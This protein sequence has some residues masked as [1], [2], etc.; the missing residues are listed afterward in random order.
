MMTTSKS[1]KFFFPV[2]L[3]TLFPTIILAAT[4]DHGEFT[5]PS[6]AYEKCLEESEWIYLRIDPGENFVRCESWGNR[7][8]WREWNTETDEY[9]RHYYWGV[10]HCHCGER[11]NPAT[12]KCEPKPSNP[13]ADFNGNGS[14]LWYSHVGEVYIPDCRQELEHNPKSC[15]TSKAAN[16]PRIFSG[17]PIDCTTGNKIQSET[18]YLGAGADPLQFTQAFSSQDVTGHSEMNSWTQGQAPSITTEVEVGGLVIKRLDQGNGHS[19]LFYGIGEGIVTLKSSRPELGTLVHIDGETLRMLKNGASQVFDTAGN[20]KANVSASGH[21]SAIVTNAAGQVT[22]VSNRFGQKLEVTYNDDGLMDTLVDP[23]GL[24]TRFAYNDQ[25]N[26]ERVTFPDGTPDDLYDNPYKVYLYE[27]VRFPNFITGILDENGDRFATWTYNDQGQAITSEHYGAAEK[28]S[29]DYL[30]DSRTEITYRIDG[31]RERKEIR[32]HQVIGGSPRI[33]RIEHTQCDGCTGADEVWVYNSAGQVTGH[34][35]ARSLVTEYSYDERGNRT[36]KVEAVGTAEERITDTEWHPTL[37]LP[38]RVTQGDLVTEYVYNDQNQVATARALDAVT[39][40]VRET[41]YTYTVQGLV[42]TVD[43]PRTDLSDLMT[44]DYDALGNLTRVTNAL[45]QQVNYPSYDPHGRPLQVIDANGLSMSL[46]YTARGWLKSRTVAGATTTYDY[47]KVGQVIRIT[48]P[49]GGYINYEYDAAHRLVA[50]EDIAGN[51][52]DYTLDLLGNATDTQTKGSA[53][54]LL[55]HQR[56]VFD[57]LGRLK[58]VRTSQNYVTT[59]G[60]DGN[61]NLIT[62]QDATSQTTTRS[63][64]HLDRL[65]SLVDANQGITQ[66]A[67]DAQDRLW[68]VTDPRSLVTEYQY[69]ALG[70]LQQQVSPDTGSTQFQYDAAGNLLQ[71][72]DARGVIT[73]YQYDAFNRLTQVNYPGSPE[74][75]IYYAYDDTTNGNAGIGRLTQ[76]TDQTGTTTFRYDIRGLVVE[77]TRVIEGHTY[78]TSYT[79][80]VAQR[81]SQLTYP[82]GRLVHYHYNEL[83]QINRVTTH[84]DASATEQTVISEVSY[85]PFGPMQSLTYGNGLVR[86]LDYNQ[87]YQ[88]VG[89]HS[90]V[91][92]KTYHYDPLGNITG[93]SDALQPDQSQTFIYDPLSRLSE[94]LGG[95][96]SLSFGYDAVGNRTQKT[97]TNDTMN[98]TETYTYANDSNRLL[99]VEQLLNGDMSLRTLT[100]NEVGNIIGD[101]TDARTLALDYNAQNRLDGVSKNGEEL[102]LYLHNALGQRVIKVATDPT[103]NQHFHYDQNGLLLAETQANGD[104]QRETIYL[105]GTPVA[106]LVQAAVTPNR[107]PIAVADH[108]TIQEDGT[109]EITKTSLLLNDTD[110]DDNVLEFV[111]FSNVTP[112]LLVTESDSSLFV[113]PESNINGDYAFTYTISDGQTEVSGQVTISI[114]PVN[115]APYV[116][117]EP[118]DQALME[119]LPWSYSFMDRFGDS[120]ESDSLVFTL[121]WN[122]A[123]LPSWLVYD[124]QL[125]LLSGTPTE[126]DI[127]IHRISITATDTGNL[128]VTTEFNLTIEQHA[129]HRYERVKEGT[130]SNETIKGSSF[131]D[132]YI[133]GKSG[134]DKLYGY[135]GD[136]YLIGGNGND[137]L[138]AREGNDFMYGG[139]GRDKLFGDDGN[140]YLSGG[141]G[142]DT[143]YGHGGHDTLVGGPGNDILKGS[144]GNDTFIYDRGDGSDSISTR[145]T[146][147]NRSDILLFREKINPEDVTA[148]RDEDDLKLAIDGTLEVITVNKFFYNNDPTYALTF[149]RFADGTEWDLEFVRQLI[150][151]Q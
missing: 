90:T 96:G 59:Y 143:L 12:G 52:I 141:D 36:R 84:E 33:T 126:T 104:I 5:P 4:I 21:S 9:D 53:G 1:R 127:G 107:A 100:Y 98:L 77:E 49:N 24:I 81:L 133:D 44:F 91:M 80:D 15:P 76:I 40:A 139:Q 115:K 119:S 144:S 110:P 45:G 109:L 58:Q 121:K 13:A 17:N 140:D 128:S 150:T 138:Y 124:T 43:G 113:S 137:T 30:D 136:D 151:A 86:T 7:Y 142:D 65:R 72:T 130:D 117:Y 88:L 29:L 102:A 108:F 25:Q 64:D 105:H 46:T 101:A 145:D 11:A 60:Y 3:F 149:I 50:I 132:D 75:N 51:R 27:D 54:E 125:N 68:A 85:L 148:T 118:L 61:G 95:Y 120:D 106:V 55:R 18:F 129:R 67:Y 23:A 123:P 103:A 71:K 66:F 48:P 56:Q 146:G 8:S 26:L 135:R 39:N 93:I 70:D 79:Y 69:N 34:T 35:D 87:D 2:F 112:Q 20:L 22:E 78:T 37:S 19:I 114:T 32:H 10:E 99:Q 6:K 147:A 38:V 83:G 63:F 111:G 74:E 47:D 82:S 116:V 62:L 122:D 31:T 41:H 89:M 28:V 57:D 42:K 97:A 92:D 73:Q 94:A 134:N 131:T 16:G 14:T